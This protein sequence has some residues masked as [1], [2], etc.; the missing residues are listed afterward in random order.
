MCQ[1]CEQ[2]AH[3]RYGYSKRRQHLFSAILQFLTCVPPFWSAALDETNLFAINAQQDA[4]DVWRY[5]LNE[6][7]VLALTAFETILGRVQ[8][9]VPVATFR[10][11]EENFSVLAVV[12]SN[13]KATRCT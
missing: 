8:T 4:A 10:I 1:V 9:L 5:I 6:V 12:I 3:W 13:S 7:S 11:E 2:V